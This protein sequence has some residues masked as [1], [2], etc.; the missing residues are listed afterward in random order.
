VSGFSRTNRVPRK[1]VGGP[2]APHKKL[3]TTGVIVVAI[4]ILAITL[5]RYWHN[6]HWGMR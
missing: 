3:E 5:T 6:I 1:S 2:S 4:L